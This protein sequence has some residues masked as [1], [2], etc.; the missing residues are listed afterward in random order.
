MLVSEGFDRDE[1]TDCRLASVLSAVAGALNTAA[2]YEVGFFSANMTG[3]VAT[4]SSRNATGE[5]ISALFY[6]SVVLAFIA[7]AATSTLLINAGRRRYLSGIYA[8]SIMVEAI[9]LYALGCADLWLLT[10]WR[11][12]V[13]VLGLAFLMGIQ[14]AVVTRISGARVRTTH[15][16][17]IATDIGIEL[18]T[19]FDIVR[20]RHSKDEAAH[21]QSKLRLHLYTIMSFLIGGIAGVVI[22]RATGGY[23]LIL[24]AGVLFVTALTGIARSRS[25]KPRADTGY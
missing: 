5:W 16:S 24:S 15:V 14:N 3:N 1:T 20:G 8:Y 23:L 21:N 22:Y 7:G 9:L 2:F 25:L 11:V 4:F 10:R 12:P 17:G 6:L 19:A 13:L 18:A